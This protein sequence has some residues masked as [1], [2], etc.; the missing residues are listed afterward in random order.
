MRALVAAEIRRGRRRVV[1]PA[2][3]IGI[4]VAFVTLTFGATSALKDYLFR[5]VA[6][7][8]TLS[9][10]VVSDL[11]GGGGSR[12]VPGDLVARVAAV[13]GVATA[14]PQYGTVV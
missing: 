5:A 1:A 14:E 6:A 11:A 3:A 12:P 8:A 4:A 9:D 13:P 7:R 10:V 2:V